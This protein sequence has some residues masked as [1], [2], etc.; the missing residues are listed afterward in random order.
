MTWLVLITTITSAELQASL[1]ATMTT[2]GLPTTSWT[3]DGFWQNFVNWIALLLR[4]VFEVLNNIARNSFL[5][6]ATAQGLI[7]LGEGTYGT[8]YRRETFA[9][10]TVTLLNE[11]GAPLDEVIEAISFALIA[12]PEVTYK[13]SVVAYA[14]NGAEVEVDIVCDVAGTV[15]NAAA[16]TGGGVTIE[17]VTTLTGVSVVA[18]SAI[19]GQD[20][21]GEDQYRDL[22]TKQA[23]SASTGHANKY[24]WFAL[25]TNTDG[26][27]A[28]VGDGKTRV[29]VNRVFVSFEDAFGRVYVALAS[30]SG[31][32]DSAEYDTTIAVLTQYA[33]T[34]PGILIDANATAVPVNVVADVVLRKGT[35]TSGVSAEIESRLETYFPDTSIGG[36]DGFL[37][38]EELRLE[39]G[40]ANPRIH[41]VTVTTP[42]SDVALAADEVATLGTVTLNI[43]VQA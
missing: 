15:G 43:T 38:K 39:I 16:G 17:L 25:N 28:E 31:S 40:R 23:A 8:P 37:T 32:V 22:C 1:L 11:S 10:G 30:P 6:T 2:A 14:L 21:Q 27:I 3:R 5:S 35:S 34:N 29:N 9:T 41:A 36:D 26:T 33:L 18:N 4:L 12:D 24:E 42:A 13:N 19:I 7:D 20:E